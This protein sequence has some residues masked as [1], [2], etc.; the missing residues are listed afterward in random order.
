MVA[1]TR[2]LSLKNFVTTPLRLQENAASMFIG[3]LSAFAMSNRNTKG[4]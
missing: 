3:L 2:I 4:E 1:C